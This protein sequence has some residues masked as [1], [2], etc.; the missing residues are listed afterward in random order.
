MHVVEVKL[1]FDWG[2]RKISE[3]AD[4]H[5]QNVRFFQL[6]VPCVVFAN[7]GQNQALQMIKTVIDASPSSL[8]QQ[9]FKSLQKII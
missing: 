2:G 3:E 8:L 7:K 6:G 9:G 4:C 1:T 5:F